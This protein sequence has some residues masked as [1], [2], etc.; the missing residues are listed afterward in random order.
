M[1]YDGGSVLLG[2]KGHGTSGVIKAPKTTPAL[3]GVGSNYAT[4]LAT[5]QFPRPFCF[6]HPIHGRPVVYS[7]SSAAE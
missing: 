3:R 2:I 5:T 4:L 6:A 7:L 1:P